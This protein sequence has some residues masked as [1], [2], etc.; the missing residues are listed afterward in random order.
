MST[1]AWRWFVIFLVAA[2]V[3][4]A[5][6]IHAHLTFHAT[7]GGPSVMTVGQLLGWASTVALLAA[8]TCI[9]IGG[10]NERRRSG[11]RR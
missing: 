11:P 6:S 4:L 9:A 1:R 10:L 2:A 5:L 3:D 8:A 7:K